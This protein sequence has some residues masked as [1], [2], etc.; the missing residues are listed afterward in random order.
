MNDEVDQ[1]DRIR[2]PPG[3]GPVLFLTAVVI[4][5]DL[6]LGLRVRSMLSERS[7]VM[8]PVGQGRASGPTGMP[9]VPLAGQAAPSTL[10]V[11]GAGAVMPPAGGSV[12]TYVVDEAVFTEELDAY[13]RS[14]A[15]ASGMSADAVPTAR[16]VYEQMKRSGLLPVNGDLDIQ[17]V[18]GGHVREMAK[19]PAGGEPMPGGASDAGGGMVPG[20]GGGMPPRPGAFQPPEGGATKGQ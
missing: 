4:L 3:W 6:A 17:T 14:V 10:A 12:E 2:L 18:L 13:V 9:N 11:P 19:H 7:A 15:E 20:A 1:S 5:S 16:Q 8:A